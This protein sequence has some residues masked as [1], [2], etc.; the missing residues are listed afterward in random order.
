M[1]KKKK[2][3][4]YINE[5]TKL[6]NKSLKI[7]EEAVGM[8]GLFDFHDT[9]CWQLMLNMFESQCHKHCHCKG[10][11][12]DLNSYRS[13]TYHQ[14]KHSGWFYV[15]HYF[16]NYTAVPIMLQYLYEEY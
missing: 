14:K 16:P 15:I 8:Q 9:N 7:T 12:L 11:V 6:N 10:H 2:K 3:K 4:M 1:F 13:E 5:Q